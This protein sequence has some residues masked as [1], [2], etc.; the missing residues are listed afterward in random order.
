MATKLTDEEKLKIQDVL[1]AI[2]YDVD[3]QIE[4]INRGG[5]AIYAVEL[6][7]RL[8]AVGV[9]N[10]RIR[11][12]TDNDRGAKT[13][14]TNVE[15][16]VFNTSLPKS[17]EKWYAND[18]Y[19]YHVRLEWSGIA[20]DAAGAISANKAKTWNEWYHR[21]TGHISRKAMEMLISFKANWTPIFDRKQVPKLKRIMDKHFKNAGFA[22]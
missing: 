22:V 7:K 3:N 13:N 8:E 6:A 12:Y 2:S 11:T 15:K 16:Q 21:Q 5:C 4:N 17:T 10:Y 18:V 9:K 19:F 1:D 20:W 14:V